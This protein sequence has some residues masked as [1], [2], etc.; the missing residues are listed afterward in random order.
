MTV[1]TISQALRRIKVLKGQIA[2][3]N[4]RALS[5]VTYDSLK[6]PAFKFEDSVREADEFRTELLALETRLTIANAGTM[7]EFEG[8]R[9]CLAGAIRNLQEI[10]GQIA[11]F[12][13]LNCR[14]DAIEEVSVRHADY[15]EE[16]KRFSRLETT[17][18]VCDLPEAK[19][20][21]TVARH[22]AMFDALNDVVESANHRTSF[23]V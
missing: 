17:R 14:V 13:S 19:R 16:G 23:E 20:A 15:D 10:K 22:Q 2:E 3:R 4:A 7:V 11:W 5:A 9:V 1:M 21:K 6:L 18:F 12:K 8:K